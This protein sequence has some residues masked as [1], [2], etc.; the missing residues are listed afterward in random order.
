MPNKIIYYA[1]LVTIM[2]SFVV[3]CVLPSILPRYTIGMCS[4]FYGTFH[5]FRLTDAAVQF[6]LLEST[7]DVGG[8]TEG[9]HLGYTM[10]NLVVDMVRELTECHH[11]VHAFRHL[12]LLTVA[13]S[14]NKTNNP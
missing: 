5:R 13:H 8:F 3:G 6:A 12:Q 4:Y 9:F 11:V 14:R 10:Q 7:Q 1:I 2:I